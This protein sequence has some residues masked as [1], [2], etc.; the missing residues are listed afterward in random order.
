MSE[1]E[2][3]DDVDILKENLKNKKITKDKGTRATVE[4]VLDQRTLRF[5]NKLIYSG[6]IQQLNGC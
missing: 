4:N 2:E 3:R 5:V 1:Y 6:I